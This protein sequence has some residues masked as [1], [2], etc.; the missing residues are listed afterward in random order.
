[1]K[2]FLVIGLILLLGYLIFLHHETSSIIFSK[3]P[4]R[5]KILDLVWYLASVVLKLLWNIV[6]VAGRILQYVADLCVDWW[7][8]VSGDSP[9]LYDIR[10][11]QELYALYQ[12]VEQWS[13]LPWQILWGIHAEETGLGRN[14]GTT[15]VITV[16]P[17][18]QKKYFFQIC[19]ELHW[20]PERVYGSHRG[21]I[22]PFQFIPETWI[23]HALDGNGD[24][25]K[26]PFNI[27]DAA[28]TAANYLLHKG[29]RQDLQKAIWHYN[30][31][32]KYVRRVMRY[33]Q[34][35]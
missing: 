14:L 8:K 16:L 4:L 32:P 7:T 31:D 27:E 2:K 22:G 23:R 19:R 26:D 30:Q 29:G 18:T 10:S 25:V 17:S 20:E 15:R 9:P 21:A 12:R 6:L 24:G 11:H 34:Y 5:S 13:G 3:R 28:Y 1:L 35:S 33:L